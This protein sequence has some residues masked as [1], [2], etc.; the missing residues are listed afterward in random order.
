MMTMRYDDACT[1]TNGLSAP[2]G[3]PCS[4]C[5]ESTLDDEQ[6]HTANGDMICENCRDNDYGVCD[7]THELY[8]YDDLIRTDDRFICQD[9]YDS[10]YFTCDDTD[11]VY[12]DDDG[13]YTTH[14]GRTICRQVYLDDYFTCDECGEIFPNEEANHCDHTGELRCNDCHED[15]REQNPELF[16]DEEDEQEAA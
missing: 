12:P 8:H 10:G 2:D 7:D 1:M 3:E 9:A 4:A 16:E 5:G 13:Q 11:E 6:H 15:Y 14:D